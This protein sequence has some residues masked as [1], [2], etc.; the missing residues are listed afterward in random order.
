M[1]QKNERLCAE[2]PPIDR[3]VIVGD[4]FD[5]MKGVRMVSSARTTAT[6]SMDDEKVTLKM[7]GGLKVGA[8]VE[9]WKVEVF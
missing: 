2:A 4:F 8:A 3:F 9:M 7:H 1:M 6:A 5:G